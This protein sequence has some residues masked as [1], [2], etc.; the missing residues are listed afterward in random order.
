MKTVHW[1]K[2]FARLALSGGIAG[3]GCIFGV[4]VE[5]APPAAS[6]PLATGK[7]IPSGVADVGL[8]GS[9]IPIRFTLDKPST[10]TLV[11]EDTAGKRLR[12]LIAA[13]RLPAGEN[14][15]SWDGYDDGEKQEDG[16]T[17][18]RLVAPVDIVCAV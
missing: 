3:S 14:L 1:S 12:N 6:K 9:D 17:V 10:V 18:R 16:S 5:A 15:L 7:K 8:P 13:V 11:I 2:G 4:G